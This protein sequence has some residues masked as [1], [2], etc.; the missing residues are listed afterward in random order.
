MLE[1]RVPQLGEGLREVRI[2]QLLPKPGDVIHRGDPLY[3]IETD[4][5]TVEMESPHTG[6][7]HRWVVAVD[8]V[9]PIG[10]PIAVL[11]LD[12]NEG[13]DKVLPIT[14]SRL[15]PPRTRAY[16]KSR[17]VEDS[18]LEEIASVTDKVLPSDIDA[19]LARLSAIQ[20]PHTDYVERRVTPEHRTF[21]YRLRRSASNSR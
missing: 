2:V 9:V 12:S 8:D 6:R 19:Y 11:A 4:K 20:P 13:S 15:I 17:G 7:I 18:K 16:A 1:V 3:V 21:I 10:A 5:T 14:T